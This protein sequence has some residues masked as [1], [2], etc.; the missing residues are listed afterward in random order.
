MVR[1]PGGACVDA[2]ADRLVRFHADAPTGG[3]VDA[4]RRRPR[5]HALWSHAASKMR[6]FVPGDRRGRAARRSGSSA[7]QLAYLAGRAPLFADRIAGGR[8]RDGHGDLL[9]DDVF[10]LADG[11]R[12]LDC[13]E[14]DDRLRFGDV[15]ADVAFLAMD[16]ERLG[17][18]DLA[19]RLL[20]RYRRRMPAISGRRR[21]SIST[22]RTARSCGRRSP[23]SARRRRPGPPARKRA[24]S[25]DLAAS[26]L[27]AGRVRLVVIGGPPATGKTTL[28]RASRRSPAGAVLHSDEVRKELA[29]IAADPLRG[30]A[31]RQRPLHSVVDRPDLR[32]AARPSPCRART[33]EQRDPRRV[34][35]QRHDTEPRAEDARRGDRE[36][37]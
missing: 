27:V 31:A 24:G 18:P 26:H 21:S 32:R 3:D 33:G 29:G 6:A 14:F 36:P 15:L 9:A 2:I 5:S 8:I 25:C 12:I 20:D 35:E 4:R 23:C 37:R 17:R 10:C 22:S 34:V 13:L 16:L 28:A 1:T 7:T 19:R 11:P 30:R